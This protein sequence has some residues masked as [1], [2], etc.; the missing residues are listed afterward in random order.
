MKPTLILLLALAATSTMLPADEIAKPRIFITESGAV[1]LSADGSAGEAQGF[2]E[3]SGGTSRRNIEVM[4]AF[5][6]RCPQVT[7]TSNRSKADYV[8]RVDS[9]GVNPTTPFVRGNKVAI[10]DRNEDLIFS[11]STKL[12]KNAVAHSCE[13]LIAAGKP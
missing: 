2:V 9:P 13:V 4:K 1:Q 3:V 7:I 12:L 8:V 6:Q 10:F 5:T 11:D